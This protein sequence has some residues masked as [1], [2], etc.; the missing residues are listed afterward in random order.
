MKLKQKVIS[1]SI[2]FTCTFMTGVFAAD[3]QELVIKAYKI[4]RSDQQGITEFVVTDAL[5]DFTDL[6]RITEGERLVVDGQISKFLGTA[7]DTL[8]KEAFSEQIVFSV[9]VAGSGAGNYTVTMEF[10]PFD[11]EK[12]D[13]DNDST[14]EVSYQLGNVTSIFEETSTNVIREQLTT[15][16]TETRKTWSTTTD[17]PAS[18]IAKPVP[19]SSDPAKMVFSWGIRPE[20]ESSTKTPNW[21]TRAAVAMTIDE[22][23][24]HKCK[25]FGTHA[26]SVKVKLKLQ[27]NS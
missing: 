1:L 15:G 19:N 26:S 5:A 13:A 11:Y 24:Y 10:S 3:S 6:N 18:L 9:R 27:E 12:T 8:D 14:I 22:E 17:L 2:L 7:G 25:Q 23:T 20:D 4:A 21:T 16:S